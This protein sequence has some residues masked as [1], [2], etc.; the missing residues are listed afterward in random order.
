MRA[1]WVYRSRKY[2]LDDNPFE[3]E[4]ENVGVVHNEQSFSG[5]YYNP[6]N[7]A[8]GSENAT[9]QVLYDSTAYTG[10]RIALDLEETG[11]NPY[12]MNIGA[13]ARPDMNKRGALI[14]G[15]E[16]GVYMH[17]ENTTWTNVAFVA[18]GL[19]IIVAPQDW[20]GRAQLDPGYAMWQPFSTGG[21][22]FEP[23]VYA[24]GRGNCWEQRFFRIRKT[25]DTSYDGF[26]HHRFVRFKR[27][28]EQNEGLFLYI[29]LHPNSVSFMG[30][31]FLNLWCRTLVTDHN[32]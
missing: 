4:N 19:R 22:P 12:R 17:A 3:D 11:G 23:S 25:D 32:R 9:A 21:Q 8:P 30:N 6:I 24:N 18:L 16:I 14:H 7:V 2:F 1:D 5:S 29:E 26:I 13:E 28:L 15:C 31:N 27:R 20:D 10:S